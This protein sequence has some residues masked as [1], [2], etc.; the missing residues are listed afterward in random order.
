MIG[1]NRYELLKTSNGVKLQQNEKALSSDSIE[2]SD[3]AGHDTN[4][5]P[6]EENGLT[7]PLHNKM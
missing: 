6:K 5:V 1:R 2:S 7:I 4:H 3:T